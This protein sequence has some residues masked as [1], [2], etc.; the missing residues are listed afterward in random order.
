MSGGPEPEEGFTLDNIQEWRKQPETGEYRLVRERP[1]LTWGCAGQARVYLQGGRFYT[2]SGIR[3]EAPP[4]WVQPLVDALTP[5]ERSTYGL[6]ALV[7]P[8]RI[9][10]GRGD[11]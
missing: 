4:T 2:E 10:G 6:P 1:A 9:G 7:A 5:A 8:R 11:D 3:L